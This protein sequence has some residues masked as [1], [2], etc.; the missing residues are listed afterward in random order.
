MGR[1]RIYPINCANPIQMVI[2]IISGWEDVRWKSPIPKRIRL[3][4]VS[5]RNIPPHTQPDRT[6]WRGFFEYDSIPAVSDSR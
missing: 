4:R 2:A 1:N 6:R 3:D 5:V